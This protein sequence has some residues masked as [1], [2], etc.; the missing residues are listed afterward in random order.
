MRL[1]QI[2][3][4]PGGGTGPVGS[5]PGGGQ[6]DLASSPARKKA[7]AKALEDSIEPGTRSAGDWADTDTGKAVSALDGWLTSTALKKAHTTWGD[8]VTN[9][10]NRLASDK[11]ALRG[12]GTLLQSTDLTTGA[13][14]RAPSALDGF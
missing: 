3:G 1:N 11:A 2:P 12:A 5:S 7:A 9:L 10:M 14:L 6:P 8:Q 13:N 4:D